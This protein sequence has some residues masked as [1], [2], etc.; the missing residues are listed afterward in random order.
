[1][2]K[3]LLIITLGNRLH[4]AIKFQQIVTEFGCII[5]TRIGLHHEVGSSCS[6]QGVIVLELTG[7]KS[8]QKA[9]A[10]KVSS[11]AGTKSKLIAIPL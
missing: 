5:R 9:L 10:K 2:S 4:S 1:M 6:N 7:D 8:R 11:L 3:A